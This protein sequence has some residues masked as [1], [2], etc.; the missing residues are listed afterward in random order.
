MDSQPQILALHMQISISHQIRHIRHDQTYEDLSRGTFQSPVQYQESPRHEVTTTV[1][2]LYRCNN[3]GLQ[4]PKAVFLKLLNRTVKSLNAE[5]ALT[6]FSHE[7]TP[8]LLIHR[9]IVHNACTLYL[10][11]E[12]HLAIFV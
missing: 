11:K 6:A 5:M 4:I 1:A 8:H 10:L 3:Q 9:S 7:S 12:E 2:F